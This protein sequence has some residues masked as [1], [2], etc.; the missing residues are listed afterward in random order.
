MDE[1]KN[2]NE[3]MEEWQEI[4][5]TLKELE[6]YGRD[7]LKRYIKNNLQEEKEELIKMYERDFKDIPDD[8]P[9]KFEVKA[10]LAKL[11]ML[12]EMR[13]YDHAGNEITLEMA[14]MLKKF[15]NSDD[16]PGLKY[17]LNPLNLEEKKN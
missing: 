13:Y 2:K 8:D 5:E 12:V 10:L 7:D 11:G 15:T 1:K 6:Q 14:E 4:Q 16:S 17:N 9:L 3:L